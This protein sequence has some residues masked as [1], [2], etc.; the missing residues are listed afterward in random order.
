M[1]PESKV[2]VLVVDDSVIVRRV[3]SD[4]LSRD[5]DLEVVGAA[6][7]PYAARDLILKLRPDV[8]TLDIEMPRMD[9]LTFLRVLQKHYPLPVVIISALTQ[10][11]SQAAMEALEAGAVD[12]LGKPSSS[13]SIGH[14]TE[15]LAQRVKGAAFAQRI[16]PR[17]HPRG[18]GMC[19]PPALR[20]YDPRQII[21]MGA[22]TGGTEALKEILTQLPAGLPGICIV[23]HIPAGF[24]RALAERFNR[25]CAF[26]VREAV[27][28]DEVHPGLALVAPG[29]YHMLISRQSGAYRVALKQGAP[30]HYTRPAV[31]V[32]FNAGATACPGQFAVAVLLTGMGYDG[33]QGM[34]KLKAAGAVTIAQ[35]EE[36]CVVFGMPRAAIELGVVDKVLP[37]EDIPQAIV[38]AVNLHRQTAENLVP[39]REI[40]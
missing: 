23:Q 20:S 3:I 33:A 32:L 26:E 40:E 10:S 12:V 28:G 7:D 5:P 36:T 22:S 37:L 8:L 38:R 25:H 21:L 9:G 16:P 1:N 13:W 15:E 39:K 27:E 19:N 31:D 30:V 11:G 14:L 17:P 4:T 24:S 35:N 18:A 34:A 2:R 6:A 29:D